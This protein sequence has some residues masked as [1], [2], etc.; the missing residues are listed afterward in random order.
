MRWT[1][2][3]LIPL[4]LS[5]CCAL[6][7]AVVD[8]AHSAESVVAGL[9]LFEVK[10]IQR[11]GEVTF[12]FYRFKRGGEPHPRIPLKISGLNVYPFQGGNQPLWHI[13]ANDWQTESVTYGTLPRFFLQQIPTAGSPPPLE[14]GQP[15]IV[16]AAGEGGLGS[17]AFTYD[18]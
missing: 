8:A 11:D 3:V 10:V 12:E 7:L 14:K 2:R 18:P 4:V 16:Q 9:G 5:A 1:C 6:W 17:T 15:Y 13:F